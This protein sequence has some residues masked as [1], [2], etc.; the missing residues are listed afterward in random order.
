VK[1]LR[2]S[3][4]GADAVAALTDRRNASYESVLPQT[5]R[6]VESVRRGGD[7]ALLRLRAKLDRISPQSL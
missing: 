3:G 6:I 1:L 5:L 4:R 7:P 2:T